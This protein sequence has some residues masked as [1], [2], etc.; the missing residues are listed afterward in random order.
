MAG[1]NLSS[2]QAAASSTYGDLRSNGNHNGPTPLDPTIRNKAAIVLQGLTVRAP[3]SG[4]SQASTLLLGNLLNLFTNPAFAAPTLSPSATASPI[5]V[6]TSATP[7]NSDISNSNNKGSSFQILATG[8]QDIAALVGLFATESVERY[9]FDIGKGFLATAVSTLSLLGLLGYV[10]LLLKFVLGP[11]GCG[12]AGFDTKALR[13]RFGIQTEDYAPPNAVKEVIYL[14]RKN[15]DGRVWWTVMRR[16]QH[17]EETFYLLKTY[18]WPS[19]Q[20]TSDVDLLNGSAHMPAFGIYLD[21]SRYLA[22]SVLLSIISAGVTCFSLMIFAGLPPY[23]PWTYFHATFGLFSSI[24]LSNT[25]WTSV[26]LQELHPHCWHHIFE[27]EVAGSSGNDQNVTDG[28]AYSVHDK[29][30]HIYDIKV[31]GERPER[32]IKAFSAAVSLSILLGFGC[33]G[34]CLWLWLG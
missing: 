34:V 23:Q 28:F 5:S 16:A 2:N 9:A 21:I 11:S 20:S 27:W 14:Q 1:R 22:L 4:I 3:R 29:A 18:E 30:F 12:K 15:D 24:V 19:D 10:R 13:P 8:T 33:L 17:T 26:H 6:N 31:I 32:T 7:N 25:L